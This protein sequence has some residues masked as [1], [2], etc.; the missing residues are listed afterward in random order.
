MSLLRLGSEQLTAT[1]E[2][3]ARLLTDHADRLDQFVV[4]T[5]RGVRV[6]RLPSPA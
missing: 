5:D 6:R 4:V 3:M 1:T 2:A